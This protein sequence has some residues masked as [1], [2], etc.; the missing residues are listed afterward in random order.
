MARE[1]LAPAAQGHV[2]EGVVEPE[3]VE[4]MQDGVGMFGLHEQVVLAARRGSRC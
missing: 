1:L 3:A 4:A 2:A